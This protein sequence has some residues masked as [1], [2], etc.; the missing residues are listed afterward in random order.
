M[1]LPTISER[2]LGRQRYKTEEE[3][4]KEEQQF[5]ELK[6]ANLGSKDLMALIIAFSELIIP[7]A[8]AFGVMYF[9]II[10][11]LTKVWMK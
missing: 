1:K 10:L 5:K 8:L 6:E 11:F 9:L 3:R 2:L 7:I 4:L